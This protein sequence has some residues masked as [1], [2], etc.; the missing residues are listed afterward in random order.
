MAEASRGRWLRSPDS[1]SFMIHG[2]RLDEIEPPWLGRAGN[3]LGSVSAKEHRLFF[4][5]LDPLPGHCQILRVQVDAD[6]V[7]AQRL[8]HRRR[9]TAAD[10]WVEHDARDRI[11]GGAGAGAAGGCGNVPGPIGIMGGGA[12][13]SV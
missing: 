3:S 13:G 7:P 10:E 9:G 6:T 4:L 11:D 1:T 5:G 2:L 12:N 8:R